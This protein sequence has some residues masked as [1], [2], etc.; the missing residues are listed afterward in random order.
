MPAY[1]SLRT[2]IN[3]LK[4]GETN[5]TKTFRKALR[6]E[7]VDLIRERS[8]VDPHLSDDLKAKLAEHG[9]E[10]DEIDH[11]ENEWPPEKRNEARMWVVDAVDANRSVAFAWEL[12]AGENPAN[13]MDDPGAPDPVRVTF[14]SPRQGLRLSWLNYGEVHVDR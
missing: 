6:K 8:S 4:S 3:S 13:S 1:S 7:G 9:M 12:F 5:I 11:L 10:S 2:F 14:L